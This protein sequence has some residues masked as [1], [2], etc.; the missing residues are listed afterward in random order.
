MTVLNYT[1]KYSLS[2]DRIVDIVN[3]KYKCV[4]MGVVSVPKCHDLKIKKLKNKK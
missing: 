2:R 4:Y 1:S 3:P